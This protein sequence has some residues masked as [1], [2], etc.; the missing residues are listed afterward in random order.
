MPVRSGR[1]FSIL[2]H[3]KC[4]SCW[5][6]TCS[7]QSPV[8]PAHLH[9]RDTGSLLLLNLE[10]EVSGQRSEIIQPRA[11]PWV[12]EEKASSPI[13]ATQ[14]ART[15]LC[16]PFRA[17][18]FFH[19]SPRALPWAGMCRPLGA[20]ISK[21]GLRCSTTIAVISACLFLTGFLSASQPTAT[22][23]IPLASGWNLVSIQ[24]GG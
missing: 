9:Q 19:S 20:L 4:S 2:E 15:L 21:S 8:M 16:R 12:G 3:L 7:N 5:T 23:V 18:D 6:W 24:I 11:T 1:I 22:Q 14:A 13:G 10:S 17:H